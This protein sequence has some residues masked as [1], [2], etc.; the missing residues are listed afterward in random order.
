MGSGE[1]ISPG[2]R[3][4]VMRQAESKKITVSER[5]VAFFDIEVSAFIL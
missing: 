1:R 5:A 2:L 3:K 4:M